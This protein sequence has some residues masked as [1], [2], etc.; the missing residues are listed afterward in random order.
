MDNTHC[1]LVPGDFVTYEDSC[2]DYEYFDA[3]PY[4]P[5]YYGMHAQHATIRQPF[6]N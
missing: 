5:M 6:V 4:L 1:V 3:L 2:E